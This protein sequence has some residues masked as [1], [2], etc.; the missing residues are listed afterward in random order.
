MTSET[1]AGLPA[2]IAGLRSL[3]QRGEL[4]AAEALALQRNALE[5]DAWHCVVQRLPEAAP[6]RTDLPLAGVGLA[7]KD[8]FRLAE[9]I[10]ACG[11]AHSW[12]HA[13]ERPATVIGRLAR[14]GSRS[15]AALSMAEY[16]CGATSENPGYPDVVNPLD[17]QAVVGGSSSGSG[18]A[19]AAGLCYGSLGTDTAGSVR[20]PAATCGV[21]GLKPTN[22]ALPLDGVA[23]LAPSLDSVG[24]LARG[25][26][27]AAR[28]WTALQRSSKAAPVNDDAPALHDNW[29]LATCWTHPGPG[30]TATDRATQDVL[31][32]FATEC[33]AK[34]ARRDIKLSR[35]PEW[36]R[37]AQTVLHTEAAVTHL[38][39]LREQ[40]PALS[41]L[42]R[43]IALPGVALPAS[44]Y[45]EA[46]QMRAAH[47]QH[48]VS[49]M[50]ADADLL[51]TPVFPAGVPD[52]TEVWTTSPSFRPRRLF[53]LFCWMSF[54]N[55]LGLPAV[56]FPV[57][58][59]TNGRPICVQ[60]IARPGDESVL[61]RFAGQ[62]EMHRF[63][64]RG[65]VR[66]P[67]Q[68]HL[69]ARCEQNYA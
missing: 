25:A 49:E 20:I 46:Q 18:V 26:D 12:L 17:P 1:P 7:H 16:A 28:I 4:T 23:P 61:L 30:V 54:V 27:D 11:S 53:E 50:L 48:F 41:A 66:L 45:R 10:P 22:G 52:T 3:I 60:A 9:R 8:I 55:Y 33:S 29:R 67:S 37:L 2:S 64:G 59:G 40:A 69:S 14:A 44:W 63:D 6:P 38:A 34:G 43:A 21:L 57:A 13:P 58:Y 65:F 47:A 32:T 5:R 62:A 31:D 42:V 36:M 39:A 15:L 56:I 24:V 19:I 51:L 68:Q 35:L